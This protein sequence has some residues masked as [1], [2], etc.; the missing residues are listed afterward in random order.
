M[1]LFYLNQGDSMN[2]DVGSKVKKL[3]NS[4]K[5]TLKELSERTDFSIG[6]LSQVERGIS[7]VATDSLAK[8]AEALGVELSY[9]FTNPRR[10]KKYVLRS[11][12]KEVYQVQDAGFIM[13]HLTN[14]IGDKDM[15]PRLIELLPNSS[16]EPVDTY[17]HEGEEFIY[18]LEGI[19]TLSIN[20]EQQDLFPGDSAHYESEIPH[21]WQ[22]NT[23]KLVKF[24]EVNVPACFKKKG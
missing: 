24:L 15:L 5:M 10:K 20:G 16:D 9:F 12:E 1:R 23:N 18:V 22:N 17:S 3:R 19:L 6:F 2:I 8:I 4:K 7:A 21:N 11:Y 13:Y 14:D